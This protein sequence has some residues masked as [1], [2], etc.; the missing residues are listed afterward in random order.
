MATRRH[1]H[2]RHHLPHGADFEH[3][4]QRDDPAYPRLDRL[5]GKIHPLILMVPA[6]VA[7]SCAFN[8][9]DRHST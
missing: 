2:R 5:R 6:A 9:A 3:R 7:A 1:R 4:Y 8:K